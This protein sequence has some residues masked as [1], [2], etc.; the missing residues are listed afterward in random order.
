MFHHLR[1]QIAHY[2]SFISKYNKYFHKIILE[3]WLQTQ[4]VDHFYIFSVDRND[5]AITK[6]CKI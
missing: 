1:I 5:K 6:S 4:T 3:I 2:L